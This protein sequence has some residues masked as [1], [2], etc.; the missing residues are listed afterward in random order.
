MDT[1]RATFLHDIPCDY[2]GDG[3]NGNMSFKEVHLNYYNL[4]KKIRNK[5]KKLGIKYFWHFYEP[6]VE[7]TW[8]GT[9]KQSNIL[10]EYIRRL[11]KRYE[12]Y[13]VRRERNIGADW[14]CENDGERLFG[15]KRHSICS[16]F[17][18]LTDKYRDDIH[19]GKGVN[20]QVKRTIHTICN[21]LGINYKQE[22][23]IC[24]SRGL[25]CFLRRFFNQNISVWIYTKI[26]RQKY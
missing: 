18:A 1:Y 13:D 15:G 19:K 9:A 16:D 6:H 21:P 8:Y 11:C 22:A 17:V 3:G 10:Y 25:F 2:W 26:F 20:E 23:D 4:I 5:S 12:V 24:F 7:L 14:F